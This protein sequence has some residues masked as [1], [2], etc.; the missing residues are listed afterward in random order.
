[1]STLRTGVVGFGLAGRVFHAPLVA[2]EPGL[3]LRAIL[4]RNPE[5]GIDAARRWPDALVTDRLDA[6]LDAVDVVVVATPNRAH[7]EIALAA[8]QA[9]RAVVVDK[10]LAASVAEAERI[11][12]AGGRVTTFQNRRWDGDFLTARALVESGALGDVVR[13]ES[14]FDRFRPTPAPGAWRELADAEEGGGLLLDLGSHLVDQ[15]VLLLGPPTGVYAEIDVARPGAAVDDDVFL[16]LT[17]PGGAR[18][19]LWM[20]AIAPLHGP[21]LRVS[22]MRAGFECSGLDPQ[23]A[24]LADGLLPGAPG[25]GQAPPGRFADASGS[26]EQPLEP[27]AYERFYAGVVAWLRDDAAPPVDPADSLAGLRILAAAR[28]SAAEARVVAV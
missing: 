28:R 2:A 19:H 27:G 1:M 22:G 20:S 7:A 9:G 13:F 6:L 4:T 26:R 8:V 24:Q 5:R 17:H 12:A 21:R 14:R 18:S 10:P 11:L 3:E 23:E 25:W 16:A 15:A